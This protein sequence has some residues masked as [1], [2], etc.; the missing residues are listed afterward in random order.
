MSKEEVE[1]VWA[2]ERSL[3]AEWG[4]D[5]RREIGG[6]GEGPGGPWGWRGEEGTEKSH[7]AG[8]MRL[9][10]GWPGQ[11]SEGMRMAAKGLTRPRAILSTG[12]PSES[13]MLLH[14]EDIGS[15]ETFWG[16]SPGGDTRTES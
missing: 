12:W 5:W 7:G 1:S 14:R 3:W 15:P 11:G 2:V 16:F 13:R 10:D 6:W 9:G 4:T 8:R